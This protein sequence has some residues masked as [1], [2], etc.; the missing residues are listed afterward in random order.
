MVDPLIC[1]SGQEVLNRIPQFVPRSSLVV[2]HRVSEA[3]SGRAEVCSLNKCLWTI[4]T[5]VLKPT[6]CINKII[7]G[8]PT[9]S[10]DASCI[11]A[12]YN[13]QICHQETR[14]NYFNS[15][16]RVSVGAVILCPRLDN[17]RKFKAISLGPIVSPQWI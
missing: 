9:P 14:V 3:T 17:P 12:Y 2:V 6:I 7:Y 10:V 16:N 1:C 4:C 11:V 15:K 5:C 13:L 8:R